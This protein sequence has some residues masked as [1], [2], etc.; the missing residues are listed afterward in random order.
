MQAKQYP[1]NSLCNRSVCFD[2]SSLVCLTTC[3]REIAHN[4]LSK[5]VKTDRFGESFHF[6]IVGQLWKYEM[7][8]DSLV[9]VLMSD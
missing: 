4:L 2:N 1:M 8:S 3:V 7:H 5:F 6:N 9:F